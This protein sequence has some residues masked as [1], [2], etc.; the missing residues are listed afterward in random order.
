VELT[1]DGAQ[2]FDRLRE[3]ALRHDERLRSQLTDEE[4]KLLA[5]LLERLQAGVQ[6][7]HAGQ[8][9]ENRS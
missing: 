1:E 2:L 7:P 3:V 5:E 4:T 8:A 9:A 6:E